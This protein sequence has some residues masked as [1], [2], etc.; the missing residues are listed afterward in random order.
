MIGGFLLVDG[1]TVCRKGECFDE[2]P[3][4]GGRKKEIDRILQV[5]AAAGRSC[6]NCAEPLAPGT[7]NS[8]AILLGLRPVVTLRPISRG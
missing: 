4:I 2:A 8:Q 7:D 6:A 5:G 3:R 1:R